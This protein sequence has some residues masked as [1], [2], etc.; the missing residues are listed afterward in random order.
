ML[1]ATALWHDQLEIGVHTGGCWQRDRGL[2]QPWET[3]VHRRAPAQGGV[4][5]GWEAESTDAGDRAPP[6]NYPRAGQDDDVYA[7]GAG[8]HR[9]DPARRARSAPV[10]SEI[11]RQFA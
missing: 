8:S 6:S 7:S 1:V 3:T 4:D 5:R 2:F 9:R 11:S 10:D